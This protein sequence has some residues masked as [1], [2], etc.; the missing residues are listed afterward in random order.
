MQIFESKLRKKVVIC[1][2]GS[3]DEKYNKIIT[4]TVDSN[5]WFNLSKYAETFS[6]LMMQNIWKNL[7]PKYRIV[8]DGNEF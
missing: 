3:I 1:P 7:Q 5:S 6:I 2:R 8:I 4:V